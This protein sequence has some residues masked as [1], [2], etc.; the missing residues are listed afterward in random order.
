LQRAFHVAGCRGVVASLWKVDDDATQALMAL[1]YRNLWEKKL[2]PAEALRQAQ[3]TLYRHPEAVA[4]AK[5]RG[6]EDFTE[7]DLP[8]VEEK[9]AAKTKRAPTSQWAAFTFSGV[10]PAAAKGGRGR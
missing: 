9:P 4:L 2:D 6:P 7:S 8:K 10:R 3:L 1:F 5:K